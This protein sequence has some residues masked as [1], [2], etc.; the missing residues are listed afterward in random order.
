[1]T[2][3]SH[4]P[5]ALLTSVMLIGPYGLYLLWTAPRGRRLVFALRIGA[6]L[7]AGAGLAAIYLA[8]A[9]SMQSA[10][11]SE[12]LWNIQPAQHL[13]AQPGAWTSPFDPIA[14]GIAAIEVAF[15]AVLGW[16]AWRSRDRQLLFWA[17]LSIAV[18]A[19]LSGLVPG[20]WSAPLMAKVQFPWR[21]LAIEEFA[22]VS[23]AAASPWP[24]TK[25]LAVLLGLLAIANPGLTT[26]LKNLAR[27]QPN[28]MRVTPEFV[29]ALLRHAVDSAEYLPHGMLLIQGGHPAPRVP[30]PSLAS[31]PL[32]APA[33]STA[34]D[35]RTGAIHLQPAPG[36]G[37]IVLRRFYFPSW[38]V[39]CDGAVVAAAPIGPGRL[40]SFTPPPG[41]KR[42]DAFVAP[43]QPERLGGWLS[44]ASL[45]AILGYAIGA[46]ALGARRRR[47]VSVERQSAA[48]DA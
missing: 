3:F 1:L 21:A 23:L 26:D 7:V 24:T 12:F 43:T 33:V 35:A 9:L 10:I 46:A 34:S 45:A 25:G 6:A 27:G 20:F 48:Y 37:A 36:G 19:A 8:P 44:L 29:D 2:L 38:Q 31:L 22:I 5:L 18:F 15:A 41:A 13:V 28:A 17:V 11:S 30:L 42:C 32:A 39:R 14:A 40:V 47:A 16:R 4:L